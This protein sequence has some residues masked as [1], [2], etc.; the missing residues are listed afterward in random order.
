MG[1]SFLP[2][3]DDALLAWAEQFGVLIQASPTTYG[4][5]AADATAFGVVKTS[6]ADAMAANAPGVRS[7]ATVAA[8]NGAKA[9]LKTSARFLADRIQGT[10]SVT[11]AQKL[12]LGLTVRAQPQPI[13]APSVSPDMD[14]ISMIANV[15]RIRIHDAA[16]AS[17]RKPSGC[18]SANVFSYVGESAPTDPAAWKFEGGTT[19]SIFD[20]TFDAEL[21]P[22]TKCWITCQW[23]SRKMLAGPAAQPISTVIQFGGNLPMAA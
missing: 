18:V 23:L 7:Q 14:L 8:K 5:V 2:G 1:K 9:A 15:A 21:A 12:E 6:F 4:L 11:D 13:P 3:K 17:R 10:A 20:V 16:T 19:R 22:G